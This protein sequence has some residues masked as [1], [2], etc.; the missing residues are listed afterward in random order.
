[1]TAP[2]TKLLSLLAALI[3]LAV[4]QPAAAQVQPAGTGEPAYTNSQQNT[5]WLEWPATSGAD[6]YRIQYSYYANNALVASPTNAAANGGSAW[7]NWSGVATLQHG[8][9]YGICA[10][11]QYSLPNDSLFFPDGPNSCSMG[12]QLG[13]R[14]YTTIDRSKP[15]AAVTLAGGA[16][17]TNNPAVVVQTAFS[18]D[19]AG[20]FPAN[21]LCFQYGG[22]S[23]IC[24]TSAGFTYGYNSG[25]SVP[26][27]GGKAT[28]FTCTADFGAGGSPAPD[29][30]VWACVIAADASIPDNPNGPNQSQSADKANLSNPSCD[31]VVLDR[32][33]PSLAIASAATAKVGELVS[34]DTQA[35]DAVSGLSGSYAWTWGDNTGGGSGASATHT[36]TQPGTYEVRVTT[37]D[38][39]GNGAAATKVVTVT[40]PTTPGTGG[41][42]TT[43]GGSTGGGSTPAAAGSTLVVQQ[44]GGAANTQA[45]AAGALDVVAPRKLSLAKAKHGL[46]LALTADG[47]GD[48]TFAL[49]RGGRVIA[50]ASKRIT[51]AGTVAFRLKLPKRAKAGAHVLKVTFKPAGGRASTR[52]FKVALTGAGKASARSAGVRAAA[53]PAAHDAVSAAGAPVALP[54]GEFHGARPAKRFTAHGRI[55]R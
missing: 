15:S 31:Q 16:T 13:R 18:D 6:A 45:A 54:D 26:G 11:G 34:F 39:A 25:C 52:S 21:F 29:G 51:G 22:Q 38:A 42:T 9:Q 24:D 4:A 37:A 5:Q 2:S 14:A 44:A 1:M 50:R 36:F 27:S 19:I 47:A 23:N 3:V 20:P 12:T 30:P 7:V 33:A 53:A 48:A 8:G 17:Y 32:V 49:V 35:A 41:G 10:Q 55:A 46:P 40:A 28:T 43:G